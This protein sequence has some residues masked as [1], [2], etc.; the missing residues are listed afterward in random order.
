MI[1]M[2]RRFPLRNAAQE[3]HLASVPS[4]GTLLYLENPDGW[5]VDVWL[6]G[7]CKFGKPIARGANERMWVREA[8]SWEATDDVP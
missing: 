2:S 1:A 8:L 3:Y 5:E 7:N 4:D 6:N